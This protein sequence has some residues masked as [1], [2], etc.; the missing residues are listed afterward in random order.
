MSVRFEEKFRSKGLDSTDEPEVRRNILET[1]NETKLLSYIYIYGRSF[2]EHAAVLGICDYYMREPIPGLTAVCMR[3]T[4]DYWN[5][6]SEYLDILE[7]Y[8][9]I[10]LYEEWYDEIIFA[11][12]FINTRKDL[13][14]SPNIAAKFQSIIKEPEIRS[15]DIL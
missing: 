12:S 14:F 2:P 9:N 11:V 13:Q 15:L 6:Y 10:S 3:V 4:I 5:R 7:Y 8:L 1:S